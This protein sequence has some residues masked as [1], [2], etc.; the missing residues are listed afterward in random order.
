MTANRDAQE[1]DPRAVMHLWLVLGA[2][3]AAL[4]LTGWLLCLPPA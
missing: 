1:P 2:G 4:T 3:A